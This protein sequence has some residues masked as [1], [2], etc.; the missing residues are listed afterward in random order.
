MCAYPQA[1][2][3]QA[4]ALR[5][6]HPVFD[7]SALFPPVVFDYHLAAFEGEGLQ[8]GVKALKPCVVFSLVLL[9]RLECLY[10]V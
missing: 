4:E 8:A 2:K 6:H 10:L 9:L 7:L 1:V 5:K 3:R